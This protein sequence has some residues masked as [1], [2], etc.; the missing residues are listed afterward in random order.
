MNSSPNHPH[1]QIILAGKCVHPHKKE[2]NLTHPLTAVKVEPSC[3]CPGVANIQ[4]NHSHLF[5]LL[6]CLLGHHYQPG[7]VSINIYNYE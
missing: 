3:R 1:I 4:F 7:K 5:T 2:K 6:R